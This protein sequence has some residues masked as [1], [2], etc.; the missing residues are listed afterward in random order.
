EGDSAKNR[1]GTNVWGLMTIDMERGIVYMPFG[2]PTADYWGGD[3][4]GNN[5]YSTTLVA[6]DALTGK[7]KWY[8]Q[9]VHHDTWDY[10]LAAPPVLF[11]V[12]RNGQ[13]IPALAQLTKMGFLFI[14]N[15]VTGA[16]IYG[17]EERPVAVDDA[18]PGDR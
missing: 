15:R 5:L 13:P 14:L 4:K 16:P 11:D 3:R 8:F 10:D 17:V 7:V 18:R 12:K 1:S 6:A 2:E 9:A